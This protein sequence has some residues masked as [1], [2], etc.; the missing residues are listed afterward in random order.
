[1]ADDDLRRRSALAVVDSDEED[2]EAYARSLCTRLVE[3][4][5][6]CGGE[7]DDDGDLLRAALPNG[8]DRHR[9]SFEE[10]QTGSSVKYEEAGLVTETP[11]QTRILRVR[12]TM[13]V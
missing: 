11:V 6:S 9:G 5:P 8:P 13:Q 4:V 10:E 7:D 12:P 3:P 2:L 1:M